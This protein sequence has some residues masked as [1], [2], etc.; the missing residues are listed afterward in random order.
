VDVVLLEEAPSAVG[1]RIL[2]DGRLLCERDPTRR[3]TVAEGVLRRYLD[4]EYL[5][6]ELDRA[7]AERVAREICP[8]TSL[9]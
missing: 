4:E 5:R 8:L 1:Q 7:L 2:R 3:T 6:R 9:F